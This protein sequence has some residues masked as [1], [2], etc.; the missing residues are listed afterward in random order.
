MYLTE[1]IF[2]NNFLYFSQLLFI[3]AWLP[4]WIAYTL[5]TKTM[6]AFFLYFLSYIIM[7]LARLINRYVNKLIGLVQYGSQQLSLFG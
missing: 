4:I 5:R 6:Y 2:N 3:H 1:Y 7:L